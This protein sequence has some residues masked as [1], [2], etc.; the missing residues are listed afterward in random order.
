MSKDNSKP[1]APEN[2]GAKQQAETKFTLEKLRE[3][4]GTLFGVS[5]CVFAGATA[6]LTGE[7]SV[8][9]IKNTIAVWLKKEAK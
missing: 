8:S 1:A 2:T 3:N 6:N 9:E 5:D 7:Y 4:C